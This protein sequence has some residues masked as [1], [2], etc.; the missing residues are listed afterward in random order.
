MLNSL[1]ANRADKIRAILPENRFADA[2][3]AHLKEPRGRYV[4]QAGLL[5]LPR[6]TDEVA[7]LVSMA[8]DMRVPVVPYGGG[9]G[10]V[11][12]QV[13]EDGPVPLILSL[14]KMTAIRAT[15]SEEN[16][17]IAEAG[18]ILADVQEAAERVD[19]LFPLSLAAEGSAR[20]GGNL[21]TNAGGTGVLRYGNARDLCLGV[22]AVLPSGQI[23][24]GLSRLRKDNTGYDLRH[25][26]IGAE[27]TLGV[28]T[29]AALK[30]SPRPAAAGTALVQVASPAAALSLLSLVRDHVGEGVSAFELIHSQGFAFLN[31]T[32][33]QVRNPW[34][35]TPEWSV[36]IELGLSRGQDPTA[37]LEEIF[38]AAS[39]AGFVQD[40]MI[41]Q[42]AQQANDFWTIRES[43][44]EANRRIGSV[45]SHDISVPLGALADFIAECG[46]GIARLGSFRINCFGHV[47][48]GN[49][50][51]NVFPVPGKSRADHEAERPEIKRVVHELV[52]EMGG[53]VSAEHG[54]GRLKV[55]DLERY[56]DPAKLTAMR[57]IK[58][59][60]DPHGIM[61]PGAVLRARQA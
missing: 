44:P 8:S 52:H 31:E 34:T 39:K 29:A 50:H 40:G 61:N 36:L 17:L 7:Q 42:S 33:P 16:V 13:V 3:A 18:V 30:L 25:L 43:I 15:Y 55:E 60:L 57:A 27:G 28:I 14:E 11:G 10:L 32:L 19:R 20:I 4:G 59:A 22:E 46:R 21:S 2:D 45:S 35:E 5:A 6:S 54:V 51:Y 12:G 1:T 53:S 56:S 23:Y 24:H 49:L 41:A 47:G 48:D 9:T 38:V 26:L 58:D 37:A